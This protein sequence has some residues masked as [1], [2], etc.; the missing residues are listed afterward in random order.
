MVLGALVR[1]KIVMLM[2]EPVGLERTQ[3]VEKLKWIPE[4]FRDVSL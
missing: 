3:V 4:H 2:S 1:E